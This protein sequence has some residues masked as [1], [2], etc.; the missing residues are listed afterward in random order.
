[1]VSWP[2]SFVVVLSD[3]FLVTEVPVPFAPTTAEPCE[4]T[5]VP[6]MLPK[7]AWPDALGT[8]MANARASATKHPNANLLFIT[9]LLNMPCYICRMGYPR[10]RTKGFVRR[11]S[12]EKPKAQQKCL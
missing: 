6:R 11:N 1:M 8:E 12:E 10:P 4:S 2:M 9:P 7:T 3:V 5:T